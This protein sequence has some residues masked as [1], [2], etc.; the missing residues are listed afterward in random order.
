ML[1]SLVGVVAGG[2][3]FLVCLA[4]LERSELAAMR[5]ARVVGAVKKSPVEQAAE[6]HTRGPFEVLANGIAGFLVRVGK[7]FLPAGSAGELGR[8][9]A[10]AGKPWNLTPEGFYSLKL[11]AGALGAAVLGGVGLLG[12]GLGGLLLVV[13]GAAVGYMLPEFWLSHLVEKRRKQV[14]GQLLSFCD[15]L[16]LCCEAGLSLNEAV[17]RVAEKMPGLLAELFGVA[18]REIELGRPRREALEAMTRQVASEE[19]MLFVS[20]LGEAERMGT[21]VAEVMRSQAQELRRVRRV[22]ATE[23]AQKASVKMLVPVVLFM[24]IP[25]M[26][27]L[28]APAMMNLAQVLGF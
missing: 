20:A 18:F 22:R 13:S 9:L 15:L 6:E 16:A 2:A 8:K 26:V 24:F 3:V 4:V 27:L 23:F 14:D 11:V 12:S 19:L 25:M 17:K 10:H 7:R 21:P 5:L 1:L 28:L